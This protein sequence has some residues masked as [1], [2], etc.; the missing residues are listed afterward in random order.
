MDLE[1]QKPPIQISDVD[2]VV[3]DEVENYTIVGKIENT[4]DIPISNCKITVNFYNKANE[5]IGTKFTILSRNEPFRKG[6][7]Y[8]F[9][10]SGQHKKEYAFVNYLI[11]SWQ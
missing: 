7:K 11:E 2:W 1:Q 6:E 10:I 9:N 4:T 3:D 8:S 5:L